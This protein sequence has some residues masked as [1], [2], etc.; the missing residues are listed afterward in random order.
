[1]KIPI[2]RPSGSFRDVYYLAKTLFSGWWGP[3]QR[4]KE[5]ENNFKKIIG[6]T[7]CISTNS[8]T[9]A[10]HLCLQDLPEN[11]E[12]ILPSM[13]YVAT[14]MPIL[15]CKLKPV[16]A[17]IDPETL[18]IDLDDVESKITNKTKAIIVVHLGG[19]PVDIAKLLQIKQKYK[20]RIIED[21]AHS[22][23]SSYKNKHTGNFGDFGCFS[24]H[25][26]KNIS[27]GDGGAIV[28]PE[29]LNELRSKSNFSINKNT[30]ERNSGTYTSD[31]EIEKVGYK[32]YMNDLTASLGLSQLKSLK[33]NNLH[34]KRIQQIYIRN[35]EKLLQIKFPQIYP[36]CVSSNHL[37][38]IILESNDLRNKLAK[39]L[40]SKGISTGIHYKPLFE[41]KLFKKYKSTPNAKRM[42]KLILTLPNY[43]KL[44]IREVKYI[45]KSIKEFLE[46]N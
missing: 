22:L 38:I 43:S 21:C 40:G 13:T 30:F 29:D 2:S 9:S 46:R 8:A 33:S 10:I 35:L 16:F 32:Y 36:H 4:V 5:F 28:S 18:N 23:G 3:G 1:M 26:V 17:D 27:T 44:K 19:N 31:Y 45:C 25:A 14:A 6:S 34:R 7:N 15:Y 24:F 39:Y 37:S 41:Y 11:S 42:G 12:V 20:I